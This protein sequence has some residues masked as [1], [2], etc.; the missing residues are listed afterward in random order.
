MR[1][2]SLSARTHLVMTTALAHAVW[3]TLGSARNLVW[4]SAHFGHP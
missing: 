4:V 3:R 1:R 2:M